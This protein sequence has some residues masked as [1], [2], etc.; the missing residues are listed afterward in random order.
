MDEPNYLTRLQSK[1]A[2]GMTDILATLAGVRRSGNGWTAR[3]PSS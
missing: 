2:T 3:C 1:R